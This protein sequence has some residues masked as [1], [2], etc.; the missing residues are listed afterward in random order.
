MAVTDAAFLKHFNNHTSKWRQLQLSVAPRSCD[1]RD[2]CPDE[3]N[4]IYCYG[5]RTHSNMLEDGRSGAYYPTDVFW[6]G[7]QRYVFGTPC[8]T[9]EEGV[10]QIGSN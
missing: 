1:V 5:E 7:L 6:Y 4:C 9:T 3:D 8:Y 2:V 10:N